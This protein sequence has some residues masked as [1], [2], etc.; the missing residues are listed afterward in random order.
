[1]KTWNRL[2]I[3]HKL[4][5]AFS[6]VL[7]IVGS[8]VAVDVAINARVAELSRTA[9]ERVFPLRNAITDTISGVTLADDR[10]SYYVL[11][12][13]AGSRAQYLQQFDDALKDVKTAL[14]S[15]QQLTTSDVDRKAIGDFRAW[16]QSY[17]HAARAAFDSFNRGQLSNDTRLIEA[18]RQKFL[19]ADAASGAALLQKLDES[20][21]RHVAESSADLLAATK[22]ANFVSIGGGIV[23]FGLSIAL[24]LLMGG[25]IGRRIGV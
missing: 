13:K 20:N 23:A 14:D 10:G 19:A 17:E 11:A 6:L 8:V 24:A 1:M 22:L 12:A 9:T 18:G 3:K 15:A 16:E 7:L 4:T 5:A 21:D 25:S 2:P